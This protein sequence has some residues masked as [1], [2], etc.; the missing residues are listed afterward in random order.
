[1]PLVLLASRLSGWLLCSM[2]HS[3]L[4]P[5]IKKQNPN[6][7]TEHPKVYSKLSRRKMGSKPRSEASIPTTWA[8]IEGSKALR[9]RGRNPRR[10]QT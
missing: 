2:E 3:R 4:M 1:M 8:S 10:K 9:S 5:V 7:E 6:L